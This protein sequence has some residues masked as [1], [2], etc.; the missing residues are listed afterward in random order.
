MA[1]VSSFIIHVC[2]L[3][4]LCSG[5]P[6]SQAYYY[7]DPERFVES[8]FDSSNQFNQD[9]AFDENGNVH[10]V[11]IE[12]ENLGSYEIYHR[13]KLHQG[14]SLPT[15]PIAFDPPCQ[16]IDCGLNRPMFA[17][18]NHSEKFGFCVFSRGQAPYG[19]ELATIDSSFTWAYNGVFVASTTTVDYAFTSYANH[20][21]FIYS[22]MG[23]MRL[24][25]L[26]DG[27][28]DGAPFDFLPDPDYTLY[29]P[30]ICTDDE[31]FLYV[32]YEAYNSG[33]SAYVRKIQR[34]IDSEDVSAFSFPRTVLGTANFEYPSIAAIGSLT[35]LDLRVGIGKIEHSGTNYRV[36]GMVEANGTWGSP[37]AYTGQEA[38][39]R[40]ADGGN[41]AANIDVAFGR[42]HAFHVVWR[43]DTVI[44]SEAYASVTFDD[45]F[46]FS[47]PQSLSCD[48]E[49]HSTAMTPRIAAS[50]DDSRSLAIVFIQ[51][52]TST[53][54]HPWLLHV[55]T[56]FK[57]ACDTDFSNWDV[58]TGVSID[59]SSAH[60]PSASF[61]LESATARGTL[62]R[63]YSLTP[64]NGTLDFWFYDRLSESSDFHLRIDGDDG[65]KASVYRMIGINNASSHTTYSVHDGSAWQTLSNTRTMDWH[66]V[67]INVT[68]TGIEMLLDPETD[69]APVYS[70]SQMIEIGSIQFEGGTSSDPYNLDDVT[71]AACVPRAVPAFT[72]DGIIFT[73]IVLSC[74]IA[75]HGIR[76]RS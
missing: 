74:L 13:I 25:R 4:L 70:S 16:S 8:T 43:D 5:G 76:R 44:Q 28:P 24:Q 17:A 57:D 73:L 48:T 39:I 1:K 46:S 69:P 34:S 66:H 32:I 19:I 58:A 68:N 42:D 38:L 11:W 47:A 7:G 60:S 67:L 31:G 26:T 40:L 51:D 3:L 72:I 36:E 61:R 53:N 20:E 12:H 49:T 33:T 21:F 30:D 45:A 15:G 6:T 22:R 59:S 62:S 63:D 23:G 37:G 54:N 27:T 64:I 71:I 14:E 18:G 35:N 2:V 52:D 65:T 75:L 41:V 9:V 50:R 10:V 29:H 56:H 55:P